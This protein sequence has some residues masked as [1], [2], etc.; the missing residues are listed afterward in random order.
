M[1][2]APVT[3]RHILALA[4]AVDRHR[5]PAAV[6]VVI[7]VIA[8]HHFGCGQPGAAITIGQRMLELGNPEG[9][10]LIASARESFI[11]G[12]IAACIVAG[13]VALLAAIIVKWKL[14]HDD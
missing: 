1:V 9:A 3:E 4:I 12:M 11:E 8:R 6:A 5:V 2:L 14:P 10:E 13:V 7:R